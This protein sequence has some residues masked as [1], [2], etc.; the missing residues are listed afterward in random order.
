MRNKYIFAISGVLLGII[1]FAIGLF[2]ILT[3][4]GGH[5]GDLVWVGLAIFG[6]CLWQLIS[7]WTK[8]KGIV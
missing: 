5:L 8:G 3:I 2:A 6:I 7:L 4:E 1:L